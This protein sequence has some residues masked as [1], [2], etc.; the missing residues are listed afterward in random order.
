[1]QGCHDV[2]HTRKSDW[3]GTV[4]GSTRLFFS[5]PSCLWYLLI[6]FHVQWPTWDSSVQTALNAEMQELLESKVVPWRQG[7][8]KAK[9]RQAGD[10]S[11]HYAVSWALPV[12]VPELRVAN[13][14]ILLSIF[15]GYRTRSFSV[16]ILC[17]HLC[18]FAMQACLPLVE[19]FFLNPT[20]HLH[21]SKNLYIHEDMHVLNINSSWKHAN[22]IS[23]TTF[24]FS[25]YGCCQKPADGM[26]D[27]SESGRARVCIS[28]MYHNFI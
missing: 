25:Q 1:M 5:S 10:Q 13:L 3:K 15:Q 12:P 21:I 17:I 27:V 8:A 24:M 7:K 18:V 28:K 6:A 22:I 26:L 4:I 9:A 11:I 20:S 14:D 16:V 2:Q 23:E 19:T